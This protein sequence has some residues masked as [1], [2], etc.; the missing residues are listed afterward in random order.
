MKNNFKNLC[1][2]LIL[3]FSVLSACQEEEIYNNGTELQEGTDMLDQLALLMTTFETDL[4]D[5][6]VEKLSNYYQNLSFEEME[7]L[8]DLRHSYELEHSVHEPEVAKTVREKRHFMNKVAKEH[9]ND[10]MQNLNDEQLNIA[11]RMYKNSISFRDA[12][13]LNRKIFGIFDPKYTDTPKCPEFRENTNG[14]GIQRNVNTAGRITAQ[15]KHTGKITYF[16]P[17]EGKY[18]SDCDVRF[19]ATLNKIYEPEFVNAIGSFNL[20]T[21]DYFKGSAMKKTDLDSGTCGEFQYE[22]FLGE[23]RIEAVWG[24]PENAAK[25][26][27]LVAKDDEYENT[28]SFTPNEDAPPLKYQATMKN[29]TP[30]KYIEQ[31]VINSPKAEGRSKYCYTFRVTLE[32]GYKPCLLNIKDGCLSNLSGQ[33]STVLPVWLRSEK[34][35]NDP[36]DC[37]N[38]H[39]DFALST[40]YVK[41]VWGSTEKAA[42]NLFVQKVPKAGIGSSEYTSSPKCEPFSDKYDFQIGLKYQDQQESNVPVKYDGEVSLQSGSSSSYEEDCRY[43]FKVTLPSIY[44]PE[45]VNIKSGCFISIAKPDPNDYA[46][47]S[48]VGIIE[49]KDDKWFACGNTHYYFTFK[50]EYVERVWG[51]PEEAA[52]QMF[53]N[54]R[55]SLPSSECYTGSWGSEKWY[56][57]GVHR[58]ENDGWGKD[59]QAYKIYYSPCEC[60]VEGYFLQ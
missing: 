44:Y 38:T 12:S 30:V 21:K 58:P 29:S 33:S 25:N 40:S 50:K 5:G 55:L 34:Q 35:G 39:W 4:P 10:L 17:R 52:S 13:G 14:I 24:T 18:Q 47:I 45:F 41:S 2:I 11:V 46:S 19:T 48:K 8:I 28:N 53:T 43:K 9:Y 23:G 1:F 31:V 6:K 56:V 16:D 59:N 32:N 42:A 27:F 54:K 60:N 49:K 22:I 51:N 36:S 26:L 15:F 20:F 3:V 57:N 37:G 7:E